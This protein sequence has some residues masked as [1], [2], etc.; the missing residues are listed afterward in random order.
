MQHVHRAAPNQVQ[1]EVELH[2]HKCLTENKAAA[3]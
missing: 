1:I 3:I 2:H